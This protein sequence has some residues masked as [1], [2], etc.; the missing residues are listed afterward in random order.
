[1]ASAYAGMSN[2]KTGE[3][4]QRPL[5]SIKKRGWLRR[6]E[7]IWGEGGSGRWNKSFICD[8]N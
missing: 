3:K 1:M 8:F 4:K 7:K 2:D 6:K 5:I